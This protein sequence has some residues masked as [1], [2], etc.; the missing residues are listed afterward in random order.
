[1][2]IVG[3]AMLGYCEIGKRVIDS[4]PASMITSAMTQAKMGLSMKKLDTRLPSDR[5]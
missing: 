4:A 5:Y 3:G 1:M 2:V